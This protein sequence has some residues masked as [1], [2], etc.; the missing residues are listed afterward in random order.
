[1][2]KHLALTWVC[3]FL[4]A[5]PIFWA[6]TSCGG[7]GSSSS[8]DSTQT[9]SLSTNSAPPGTLISIEGLDPAEY[10]P[11]DLEIF[12]VSSEDGES[13]EPAIV[14]GNGSE[15][16][17]FAV[18][19]FYDDVSKWPVPPENPV[20][21]EIYYQEKLI[22]KAE[23][24]F[25]VEPLNPAPGTTDAIE[26]SFIQIVQNMN[27]IISEFNNDVSLE[28]QYLSAIL[29]TL[30]E[31][32]NGS[33]EYSLATTLSALDADPEAKALL[34]AL[35]VT[36]GL[37]EHISRL[38]ELLAAL[39]QPVV[40]NDLFSLFIPSSYAAPLPIG[41]TALAK[42]IQL[43]E[44]LK[45]FGQEVVSATALT[46]GTVGGAVGIVASIPQ[47]AAA[48][49]I[50]TVI[51]FVLNKLCVA[52]LPSHLTGME[53]SIED[54]QLELNQ[55]T[56]ATVTL[57]AANTPVPITLSNMVSYVLN[58]L[59]FKNGISSNLGWVKTFE[60]AL[61][62]TLAFVTAEM[63]ARLS[64]Y[65]QANPGSE[66][67][68]DMN[69]GEAIPAMTWEAT[70]S[71]RE[72]LTLFSSAPSILATLS[73]ELNWQADSEN[74][75]SSSVYV[76][77][78]S[79]SGTLL[80]NLPSW[81]T[82]AG[83]AYG[84]E[85][86]QSN[87]ETVYVATSLGLD[88]SFPE[89]LASTESGV[90]AVTAGDLLGDGSISPT[91]GLDV[92]IQVT[93]GSPEESL[94]ATDSTGQFT[95]VV[96]PEDGATEMRIHVLVADSATDRTAE[97]T[98]TVNINLGCTYV[99][100]HNSSTGADYY[101]K[102]CRPDEITLIET[103]QSIELP[104]SSM[105]IREWICAEPFE[106][107]NPD[108]GSC[109]QWVTSVAKQ[110]KGTSIYDSTIDPSDPYYYSV[111]EWPDGSYI[112]KMYEC[113][114]WV[115]DVGLFLTISLA[116]PELLG[117]YSSYPD[118]YAAFEELYLPVPAEDLAYPGDCHEWWDHDDEVCNY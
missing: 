67:A 25:T 110:F 85:V 4:F 1:M 81:L 118:C 41:D 50:I 101:T 109:P 27:A 102:F 105:H 52:A 9:V 57:T 3:L 49:A 83:G 48:Q 86:T 77:T 59:G 56:D 76:Q 15:Q 97:T 18:P 26:A 12:M 111:S 2:R 16:I 61:G 117:T 31:L 107:Y 82:Y 65:A 22:A 98:L 96:W 43:Y 20:T 42:K 87:K 36:S 78:A 95:T 84:T 75:G 71:N 66:V 38:Q 58:I 45:L 91:A 103:V 60:E 89:E 5:T 6:L 108:G 114:D 72:L 100:Y 47:I 112:G 7:G 63:Q 46:A 8:S 64:D 28:D 35:F 79:G 93:G 33:S 21:V 14:A 51:D 53:L 23:L 88:A 37:E 68:L 70:A 11:A 13:D 39:Q 104:F 55:A 74:R 90:L 24:P 92:A 34:D 30:D 54:N 80:W 32:L 99:S 116:D 69:L 10:P 29:G 17:L 113:R 40:A 106:G 115:N 44:I 73:D 94:G 19:L 62:N